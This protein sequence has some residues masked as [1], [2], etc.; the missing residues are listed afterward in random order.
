MTA[1]T[2]FLSVRGLFLAFDAMIN[3]GSVTES[4]Q[5]RQDSKM[6]NFSIGRKG[7]SISPL[8]MSGKFDTQ[9]FHVFMSSS[10][11]LSQSSVDCRLSVVCNVRAPYSGD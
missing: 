4:L 8:P 9:H 5:N 6:S 11:R 1:P 10:V 2:P 3:F 7:D